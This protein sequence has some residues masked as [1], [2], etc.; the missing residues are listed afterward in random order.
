MKLQRWE[1]LCFGEAL[2]AFGRSWLSE[3]TCPGCRAHSRFL[4]VMSAREGELVSLRQ[5][6][7]V[8]ALRLEC[9]APVDLR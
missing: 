2:W 7:M 4:K 6:A 5:E 1:E 8:K 3:A 9:L